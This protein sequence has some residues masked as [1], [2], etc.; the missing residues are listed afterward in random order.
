MHLGRVLYSFDQQIRYAIRAMNSN[1]IG[2]SINAQN[3]AQRSMKNVNVSFNSYR[4]PRVVMRFCIGHCLLQKLRHGLR[5][6][7]GTNVAR[8]GLE[9]IEGVL[10]HLLLQTE[11]V[12]RER[13]V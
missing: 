3:Y 11:L 1:N 10:L 9:A 7:K 2:A 13:G 4:F 12:V 6:A 5:I 8:G